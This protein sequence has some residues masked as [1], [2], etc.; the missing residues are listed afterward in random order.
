M[1]KISL[2]E[3]FK[4]EIDPNNIFI[5]KDKISDSSVE[6]FYP[7]YSGNPHTKV[8]IVI[9][10]EGYTLSEKEKYVNDLNRFIGYF[11][12]QESYKT[13]K[14]NFNIYGVFKPSQETGTD[15]PGADIFVNTV[16]NTTFWSLGSERYL[17]TEDNLTM[18]NLAAFVPY[19]AIYIQ[20]NHRTLRRWWNI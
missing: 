9:L 1:K 5:I 8:D 12:E 11:F 2:M 4:T 20:V 15:L 18:R 6:V 16:L 19:D 10:A 14:N 3:F 13:Q 17:M 7:L